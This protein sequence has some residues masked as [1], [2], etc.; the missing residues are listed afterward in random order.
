M[1]AQC[2]GIVFLAEQ[3]S[4]TEADWFR[5]FTTFASSRCNGERPNAFGSL[6]HLTETTLAGGRTLAQAAEKNLKLVLIPTAG[7]L[8]FTDSCGHSAT[9]ASGQVLVTDL[10]KDNSFHII[11]ARANDLLNFLEFR[12]E[13]TRLLQ[14]APPQLISFEDGAWHNTMLPL[15]SSALLSL[16]FIK[17]AIGKFKGRAETTYTLKNEQN[18]VFLRVINGAFEAQNRLLEA[19]DSLALWNCATVEIEALSNEAILL[20]IELKQNSAEPNQRPR[21]STF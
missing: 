21:N 15:F 13:T 20:A 1:I 3:R 10:A 11:N 7:F 12:F 4:H 17:M 6:M 16:D 8:T 14:T 9:L 5:T 2:N 18:G 19:G